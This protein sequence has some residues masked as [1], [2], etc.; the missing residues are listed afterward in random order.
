M[1]IEAL[2]NLGMAVG[3]ATLFVALTFR[4]RVDRARVSLLGVAIV[5]FC[6]AAK[7]MWWLSAFFLTGFAL[8]AWALEQARE[9]E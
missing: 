8:K 7:G 9:H 1:M 2:A 3:I 4:S 6:C 5:A